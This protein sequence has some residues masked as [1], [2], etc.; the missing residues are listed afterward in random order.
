M[1]ITEAPSVKE[2]LHIKTLAVG[3]FTGDDGNTIARHIEDALTDI[4]I[5]GKPYFNILPHEQVAR[6][7]PTRSIASSDDATLIAATLDADA[8]LA[9]AVES[10]VSRRPFQ[11]HNNQCVRYEMRKMLGV[12]LPV[13]TQSVRQT[14]NCV[15]TIATVS[16]RPRLY[17]LASRKAIYTKPVSG[18]AQAT[19][20]DGQS[21]VDDD[22]LLTKA[23]ELALTQIK[24]AIAPRERRLSVSLMNKTDGF[25]TDTAKQRFQSG[26]E[27]VQAGRWERGCA[28]WRE[29]ERSDPHVPALL[30][31]LGLCDENNGHLQQAALD[32][33][34][35]EQELGKP[36]L[37]VTAAIERLGTQIDFQQTVADAPR[38][39][40][41]RPQ[42]QTTT[43]SQG[44]PP[45][46][47]HDAARV[48]AGLFGTSTLTNN[49]APRTN[50]HS[51]T[52]VKQFTGTGNRIALVVGNGNYRHTSVL[53]NSNNDAR[54][55]ADNLSSIGFT[56]TLHEDSDYQT[57]SKAVDDF[58]HR[59]QRD[60]VALF[61]YSGHGVQ[62]NGEN[63]L[64]P[65]DANIEAE[66]EIRYKSLNLGYLMT[67]LEGS[68]SRLN[69]VILDACRN[70]PFAS[71]FRSGT[72]GLARIDAPSG[73]L[74][75]YATAPGK[76]A[77]DGRDGHSPYTRSLLRHLTQPGL[78]IEDVFK[79][80]RNDVH[81]STGGS[82]IPWESSSLFDD[83]YF[84]AK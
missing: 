24:E 25:S 5:Q 51:P 3:P 13:C 62:V 58:T 55:I 39:Q 54:K 10:K 67:K 72:R 59:I 2:S 38:K 68:P 77:Q 21:S 33:Q 32:Y 80:V 49:L 65:I 30:Y 60:G 35:A 17:Y 12:N 44:P 48:D 31:N 46:T 37:L 84:V 53:L 6:V 70:N 4:T 78:K 22:F 75:A 81:R 61:Y 52:I 19:V 82:Q 27:F 40:S 11:E 43:T 79:L 45:A 83:F 64:I 47:K 69:I 63:Y 73:S 9:G 23:I 36:N 76:V 26:I 74:I 8:V 20:C 50:S 29:L 28:S 15:E 16:I 34:R 71:R 18:K 1:T 42:T 56:V 57:L 7:M 14:L 41:P 66:S